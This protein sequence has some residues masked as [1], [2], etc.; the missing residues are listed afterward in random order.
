ME[1]E[2]SRNMG[3]YYSSALPPTSQV[4]LGSQFLELLRPWF[5]LI[6]MP[7]SSKQPRSVFGPNLQWNVKSIQFRGLKK[8]K[9]FSGRN[10]V[11]SIWAPSVIS[12]PLYV[13]LR[14]KLRNR[15]SAAWRFRIWDD[16]RTCYH[17]EITGLMSSHKNNASVM[18]V[19]KTNWM[20]SSTFPLFAPLF[21][22]WENFQTFR[23]V[24]KI[25]QWTPN[26]P[27]TL[28]DYSQVQIKAQF[29]RCSLYRVL[30][31]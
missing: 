27:F 24:I 28:Q 26:I 29:P 16:N 31:W 4:A 9:Q 23:K 14:Y 10:C 22:Y 21:F 2:C 6:Q 7:E 8:K 13:H 17:H 30:T 15:Y 18:P 20:L 12:A 19:K 11:W 5:F 1:N 25:V 3:P